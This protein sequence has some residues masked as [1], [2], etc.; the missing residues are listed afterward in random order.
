MKLVNVVEIYAENNT[1]EGIRVFVVGDSEY[2]MKRFVGD[3]MD[4]KL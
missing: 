2:Y 1:A 4:V 3:G